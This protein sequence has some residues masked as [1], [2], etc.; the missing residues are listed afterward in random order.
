M[1]AAGKEGANEGDLEAR[2]SRAARAFWEHVHDQI[3][4]DDGNRDK[5]TLNQF[6]D[7]WA[8]LVDYVLR[9]NKLP[10]VVQDLVQIAFELY[11]TD[12]ADGKPPAIQPQAFDQ[13]FQKMN[14]SRPFAIMAYKYLTDVCLFSHLEN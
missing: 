9:T 7:T 8:S 3:P 5:L 6:L 11:S 13:L 1:T 10:P 14:L 12:N 4:L 2:L